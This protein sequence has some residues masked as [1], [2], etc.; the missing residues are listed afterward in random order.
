MGFGLSCSPSKSPQPKA[1]DQKPQKN[2]DG[3]KAQKTYWGL[4]QLWAFG[5]GHLVV[6]LKFGGQMA[7]GKWPRANGHGQMIVG[8]WS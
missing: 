7:A 2:A 1:H 3:T 4:Y 8:K 6:G 5:C